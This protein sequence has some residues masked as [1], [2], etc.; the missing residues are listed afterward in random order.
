MTIRPATAD[1]ASTLAAIHIDSWRSAYRGLVPDSRLDALDYGR[2]AEHFRQW[3]LDADSQ[4]FVVEAGGTAVG[5]C[6]LGASRDPDADQ[7]ATGEI[8]GIYLAPDHWR[9]GLGTA[10]C[11]H[12]EQ[13]LHRQGYTAA[14][15]WVFADNPRARRF[16]EAMGFETDGASKTLQMGVS[17]GA[18]RYRRGIG[19]SGHNAAQD[20]ESAGA[21]FSPVS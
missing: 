19:K 7:G 10:L 3:L 11:Q 14:T 15:L 5:F 6:T 9:K 20:G 12:A 8:W 4:I 2:R 21:A 1:D 18:V 13:T 16:Y 17:L